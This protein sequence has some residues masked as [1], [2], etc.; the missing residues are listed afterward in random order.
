[1]ATGTLTKLR[2]EAFEDA[3][4]ETKVSGGEFETG[5]NPEK[6]TFKYKIEQ[7]KDQAPGT[8]TKAPGFTKKLPQELELEFVFDRTG[9]LED[10]PATEK[11]VGPDI[12][13]FKKVILD[14][15]GNKH[16]PNYLRITWGT[17]V[18]KCL[19]TEMSIDFKLFK[20]DGAPIRA[21]AKVKFIEFIEDELR[22]AKENNKSP[23]LSHFRIVQEGDT[24]P[25][26]TFRIYGDSK[27][28]LE[29]AKINGLPN[30][31][32]LTPGQQIWFPPLEKQL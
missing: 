25:L 4:F 13:A 26:M 31:R 6:Y 14:Y 3:K 22:V 24:L 20:P 15:N 1:M 21:L 2:I 29:V 11:G 12:D 10:S 9:V 32:K 16:K 27:Y 17:L 18:F 19:M 28:Y 5:M 8:S 7:A 30:F 23:D